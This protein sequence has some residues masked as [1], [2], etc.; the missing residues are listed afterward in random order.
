LKGATRRS[1]G[2]RLARRAEADRQLEAADA[3]ERREA[4]EQQAEGARRV[5]PDA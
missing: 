3:P 4:A 5:D 2:W 1:G